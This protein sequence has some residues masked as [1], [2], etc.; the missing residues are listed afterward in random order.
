[1]ILNDNPHKKLLSL[2]ILK[3]ERIENNFNLIKPTQK[4]ILIFIIKM[5][6]LIKSLIFNKQICWVKALHHYTKF[7]RKLRK[8]CSHIY[9]IFK[10]SYKILSK[11]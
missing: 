9:I 6:E 7:E 2:F 3:I 10:F 4:N 1:M 8:S 5:F 11:D